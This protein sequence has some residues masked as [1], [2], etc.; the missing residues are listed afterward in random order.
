MLHLS[1]NSWNQTYAWHWPLDEYMPWTACQILPTKPILISFALWNTQ[2]QSN[3]L[4]AT[5]TETWLI[6]LLHII[7]QRRQ[8]VP[9]VTRH[10][11]RTTAPSKCLVIEP[12]HGDA[13][14]PAAMNTSPCYVTSIHV[15]PTTVPVDPRYYVAQGTTIY[16]VITDI[17]FPPL[18]ST[19]GGPRLDAQNQTPLNAQSPDWPWHHPWS[20]R[21]T[22]T[23][24]QKSRLHWIASIL[25]LRWNMAWDLLTHR[26][27][28]LPYAWAWPTQ[29][30]SG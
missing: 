7:V 2:R 10:C 18:P 21:K 4:T 6:I 26:I 11:P 8:Q 30:L 17:L 19:Q 12:A 24:S 28:E 9:P 15:T 25:Q 29:N 22:L 20:S 14:T 3:L 16:S 27:V 23:T 1:E 5:V 13:T